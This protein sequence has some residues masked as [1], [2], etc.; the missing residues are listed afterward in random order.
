[1]GNSTTSLFILGFTTLPNLGSFAW[2]HE[3]IWASECVL[4]CFECETPGLG[5]PSNP[6]EAFIQGISYKLLAESSGPSELGT[7]TDAWW[8]A[9]RFRK[10]KDLK[11]LAQQPSLQ[12]PNQNCEL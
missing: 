3:N 8:Q 10:M 11:P 12:V 6:H 1:M 5:C 7:G 2:I 9:Q 4:R